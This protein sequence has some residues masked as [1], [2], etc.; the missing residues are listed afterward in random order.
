[1]SSQELL[2]IRFACDK[3]K[4][5]VTCWRERGLRMQHGWLPRGWSR[6]DRHY[7]HGTGY[8]DS[9]VDVIDVC[10]RCGTKEGGR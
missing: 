7:S 6:E 10:D 3:C 8:Y 5:K 2:R 4:R 1:M 9:G